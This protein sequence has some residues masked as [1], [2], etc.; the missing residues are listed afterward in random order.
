MGFSVASA[1]WASV[2]G[3]VTDLKDGEPL[4]GVHVVIGTPGSSIGTITNR[5]GYYIVARVRPG[6]YEVTF[7][8]VGYS[9]AS[10]TIS[11]DFDQVR[12]VNVS[13]E[14]DLTTLNEVVV[15]TA[16]PDHEHKGS[17]GFLTVRPSDLE[18]IPLPGLS[19]DLAGYLTSVPGVITAGDQGG[20][21]YV[22]GGTPTQNLF[23]LDGIPIYQPMHI[24]GF[25]SAFPAEIVSFSNIYAGG[26]GS[27]YGGRLSSVVDVSSR[28]GS[29]R[30]VVGAASIAPFLGS[31]RAEIPLLKDKIS[32]VASVRESVIERIAPEVLSEEL[33]YRFGDRFAKFH[34]FLNETS[35]VAITAISTTDQGNIAGSTGLANDIRWENKAVG[36][37][38]FYLAQ[39]FPVL[40]ELLVSVSSFEM[41]SGPEAAPDQT[42][43]VSGFNGAINFGYLL[44]S[45]EAHFG[46]FAQST[47]YRYN[48]DEKNSDDQQEFIAEGGTYIDLRFFLREG[49]SIE[50]GLRVHSYASRGQVFAEPR[51]RASWSPQSAPWASKFSFAAGLYHQ[52]TVGVTSDRIVTDVF[53]AWAPSPPFRDV[54]RSTHFIA[55]WSGAPLAGVS[56]KVETYRKLI[57]RLAF[58]EVSESVRPDTRFLT[59][60]G[61]SNGVDLQLEVTRRRWF[62][63]V[64]YGISSVTYKADG[65]EFRPPH[66]RRHQLSSAFGMSLG[67]IKIRLGWQYGSGLPFTQLAGFYDDIPIDV[68][69]R[70]FHTS[71]GEPSIALGD[72]FGGRLPS[73][74]R[75]DVSVERTFSWPMVEATIQLGAVNAYN[76]SNLFDLDLFSA[77]RVNQLPVI[78]TVGVRIEIK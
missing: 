30:R 32:I 11:L 37:R 40:T 7:S 36:A 17:A 22:R 26:F 58:P 29:K 46:L 10:R 66:D 13:L 78:P 52:Q 19:S 34:A 28:N 57:D 77:E 33:P 45:W 55:G 64:G 62:G 24:V 20:Q 56:A 48:L 53:T 69:S 65:E 43:R 70:D 27:R 42:S 5:D 14:P 35:H 38:Y 31:V 59:V 63:K 60:D 72:S 15:E 67:H 47:G 50:P 4:P 25:Y 3:R 71:P 1:Q 6:E 44:G 2:R 12:H 41:Q 51:F 16:R 21:L 18:R 73:Y 23:L 8:Y 61:L 9:S 54:P 76:R 68:S 74:H 49:L 75:L 39:T